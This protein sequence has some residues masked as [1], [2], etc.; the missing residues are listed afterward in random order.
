MTKTRE[1]HSTACEGREENN[2]KTN[3]QDIHVDFNRDLL[4]HKT[5]YGQRNE[6][7]PLR[8]PLSEPFAAHQPLKD[9]MKPKLHTVYSAKGR[10]EETKSRH[11]ERATSFP[12]SLYLSLLAQKRRGER[13]PSNEVEGRERGRKKHEQTNKK[14]Y[15]P[16]DH[17]GGSYE[18]L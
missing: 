15:I 14:H 16:C 10:Q 18:T 4:D 12:G 5:C 13:D 6:L 9:E 17:T 1:S 8:L 11:E 3:K 2:K 7:D